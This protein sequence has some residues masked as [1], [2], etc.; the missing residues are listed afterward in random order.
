MIVETFGCTFLT[1][2]KSLEVTI[3]TKFFPSTTGTPEIL[4]FDVNSITSL[5]EQSGEVTT[6]FVIT[7][8]SYFLTFKT[9]FA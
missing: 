3:P 6:G 9:S 1:N 5:I 7:P 8:L 4:C 2:L